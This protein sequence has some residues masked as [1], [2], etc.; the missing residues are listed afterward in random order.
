MIDARGVH[1]EEMLDDEETG[2][3]TSNPYHL[4]PAPRGQI[5]KQQQKR[6][7]EIKKTDT[8]NGT[9]KTIV[10][11]SFSCLYGDN[12]AVDGVEL[13]LLLL[14]GRQLLTA[15][16]RRATGYPHSD[17]NSDAQCVRVADVLI[18]VICR[19]A[20]PVTH[21]TSDSVASS[22]NFLHLTTYSV[23]AGAQLK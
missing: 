5:D 17:R 2:D 19:H 23:T 3:E 12:G 6:K 18:D 7:H 4:K 8:S 16:F 15:A 11:T 21:S 9:K 14:Y 10:T 13:R 1:T 22:L 20:K